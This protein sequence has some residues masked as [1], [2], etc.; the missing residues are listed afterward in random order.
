MYVRVTYQSYLT[1]FYTCLVFQQT[2][3]RP[4]V[5]LEKFII[6]ASDILI[7]KLEIRGTKTHISHFHA[8]PTAV[9]PMQQLSIQQLRHAF[10]HEVWPY[11]IREVRGHTSRE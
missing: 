10:V 3:E 4:L 11:N 7:E 1:S 8:F 5:L 6:L 2:F 9:I